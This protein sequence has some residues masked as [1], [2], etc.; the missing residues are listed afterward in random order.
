MKLLEKTKLF[1]LDLMG[2]YQ[3][4]IIFGTFPPFAYAFWL[5][6][7]SQKTVVSTQGLGLGWI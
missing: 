7:T 1:A 2:K 3:S 4:Q 6:D 5:S